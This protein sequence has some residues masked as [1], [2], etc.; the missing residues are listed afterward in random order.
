MTAPVLPPEAQRLDDLAATQIIGDPEVSRCWEL[1]RTGIQTLKLGAGNL[2]RL[3]SHLRAGNGMTLDEFTIEVDE[4]D[5][6]RAVVGILDDQ[7]F[8]SAPSLIAE[9]ERLIARSGPPDPAGSLGGAAGSGAPAAG[10]G[11]PDLLGLLAGLLGT[12][13]DRLAGDPASYHAQ[14]QRV[15]DAAARWRTAATDPAS[16]AVDREAAEA[17]L[18]AMFAITGE[19][20]AATAANRTA[21][22]ERTVRAT[23]IDPGRIADTLR[24]VVDWLEQKTPEAG[25]AVDRLLTALDSA[26][27]P[28]L[29]RPS[30][31]AEAERDERI[32]EAA[33]AAISAR[34]K[35]L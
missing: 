1:V 32:R 17:D 10:G 30:H 22:L 25:A 28:F 3:I 11:S 14:V 20:A 2:G 24:I 29:G 4:A 5:P 21:D 16:T 18:R 15:R 13:P 6:A 31:A 12:T 8:C 19:Q 26:A 23:G 33:R 9:L 7:R 27:A 35:P 34:M